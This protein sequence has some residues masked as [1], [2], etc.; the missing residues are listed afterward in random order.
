MRNNECEN[1]KVETK[2]ERNRK[3]EQMTQRNEEGFYKRMKL[4]TSRKK[5]VTI[6]RKFKIKN[7]S[8]IFKMKRDRVSFIYQTYSGKYTRNC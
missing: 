2:A 4:E 7:N 5:S 1:E 6:K 8:V 3:S